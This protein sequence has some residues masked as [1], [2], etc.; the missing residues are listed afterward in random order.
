MSITAHFPGDSNTVGYG[1]QAGERWPV[2]L[3]QAMGWT[4][5]NI[6]VSATQIADAG[7]TDAIFGTSI[8][9]GQ[10]SCFL[11]GLNDS[12]F[13]GLNSAALDDNEQ[14]ILSLAAWLAIPST[15]RSPA[16]SGVAY[17]GGW[18]TFSV[19]NG[20]IYGS[21]SPGATASFA[22]SGSTIVIG[23]ARAGGGGNQIVTVD[24]VSKP[25]FSANRISANTDAGRGYSPALIVI[26]GLSAG[27]HNVVLTAAS[28]AVTYLFWYAGFSTPPDANVYLTGTVRMV[29]E[30]YDQYSPFNHGSDAASSA[31][32]DILEAA[33][34]VLRGAGLNVYHRTILLDTA[35]QYQADG[36]HFN[37]AG[38]AD[39]AAQM[40]DFVANPSNAKVILPSSFGFG[41]GF[42]L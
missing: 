26:T 9:A 13:Y 1:V 4:E 11:A 10:P 23:V 34:T 19:F 29:P 3:S 40:E 28:S 6:A 37:V 39:F 8:T 5:S 16:T 24:G 2:L 20:T 33:A 15:G 41:F 22:V 38:H 35:T 21:S 27:S 18:N 30:F 32:S 42:K 36:T 7:E 17:V 31:Y 12:R 25:T 14:S